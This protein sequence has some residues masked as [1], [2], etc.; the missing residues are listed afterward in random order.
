MARVANKK[1][2]KSFEK[3]VV[4]ELLKEIGGVVSKNDLYEFFNKFMTDSERQLIFRRIA[5]IK[6]LGRG[7]KY[8][9][10][11]E[12]LNISNDTISNV[13][14]ILKKRGYGRNPDRKRKYSPLI[15]NK[16]KRRRKYL[17]PRYKGG[18]SIF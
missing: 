3:E 6:L 1:L 14:D 8:R 18:E 9:K 5:T 15:L 10:I 16:Q 2:D 13:Q 17:L 11:R 7:E 12:I 4:K